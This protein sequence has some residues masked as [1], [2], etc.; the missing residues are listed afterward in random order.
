MDNG[1]IKLYR[2]LK[3]NPIMGQPDYLAVWIFLLLSVNHKD[4]DFIF[5]NQ[6]ITI[7][8][9]SFITGRNK[10]AKIL[11]VNS[12]KVERIL[13]YLE[14][15]HQ[16][17]QQTTNKFRIISICNWREYQESEQQNEQPVNN[18]RTTSEQP[19][20]TNKND[21]KNKK[22]KNNIFIIP[23]VEEIKNY[24]LERKNQIDAQYFLDY[25]TARDWKL[26]GGHKIKDWEAVIRTWEKNDY[27]TGGNYGKNNG[28]GR[29]GDGGL[30]IPKEYIPE[31]KI[32]PSDDEIKRTLA[33][34]KAFKQSA[35]GEN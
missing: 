21:K 20:N 18:Q 25:Q 28:V 23:S 35:F 15:E 1:Y 12:S 34:N 19:V 26:K 4:A 29:V 10:I 2:S 27:N 16:I 14:I 17:E 13:K 9:G 33:N 6:K 24:C 31:P 32:I 30:G 3:N 11:K 22:E 8:A 7:K 5:N